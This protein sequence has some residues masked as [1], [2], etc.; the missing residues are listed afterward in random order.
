[1]ESLTL[2]ITSAER[3]FYGENLIVL[4]G[5]VEEFLSCVNLKGE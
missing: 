5:T 4:E 2:N 1:M 3:E